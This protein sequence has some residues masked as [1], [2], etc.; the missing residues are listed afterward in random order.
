MQE[1]SFKTSKG[2]ML[3]SMMRRPETSKLIKEAMSSPLGSTSRIKAR[4]IFSIMNK[5][6][7]SYDGS[8]G[9]G[10]MYDQSMYGQMQAPEMDPVHIPTDGSKGM[11]IFHKIPK[12]KITYG[13]RASKFKPRAGSFDGSGGPGDLFGNWGTML[14]TFTQPFTDL[15]NKPT[16][17]PASNYTPAPISSPTPNYSSYTPAPVS[18]PTPP[19]PAYTPT[20]P[21]ASTWKLPDSS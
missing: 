19:P 8:G 9:P 3:K 15:I 4:K 14:N 11:V 1:F 6:N 18:S 17:P 12:P 16:T 10:M 7:T 20:P 21:P 2:E 13:N 5:L